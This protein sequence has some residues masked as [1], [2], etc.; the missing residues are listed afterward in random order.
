MT[1]FPSKWSFE[2]LYIKLP[3]RSDAAERNE[4]KQKITALMDSGNTNNRI[5]PSII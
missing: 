4:M 1:E 2:E 5:K 3:K